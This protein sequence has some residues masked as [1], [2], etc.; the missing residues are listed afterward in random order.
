MGEKHENTTR[1][2]VCTTIKVGEESS[3]ELIV[4]E[5]LVQLP[6]LLVDVLLNS[7]RLDSL[8][9]I[10]DVFLIEGVDFL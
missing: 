6:L 3:N 10:E 2:Q 5:D 8:L 9:V 7:P 4:S 1:L